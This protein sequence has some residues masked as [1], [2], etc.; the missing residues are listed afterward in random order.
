MLQYES[1]VL[2]AAFVRPDPDEFIRAEMEWHFQPKDGF[3]SVVVFVST[4]APRGAT[5]GCCARTQDPT[6]SSAT[7]GSEDKAQRRQGRLECDRT[8]GGGH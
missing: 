4:A 8:C 7:R 3:G 1:P 2:D 6:C 5:G